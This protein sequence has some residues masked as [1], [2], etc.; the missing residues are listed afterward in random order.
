M[1]TLGS[2]IQSEVLIGRLSEEELY[3]LWGEYWNETE[4]GNFVFPMETLDFQLE[5]YTK[6]EIVRILQSP[7]SFSLTDKWGYIEFQFP[8]DR[9]SSSQYLSFCV[10]WKDVMKWVSEGH[11]D[12][13]PDMLWD[14]YQ[15]IPND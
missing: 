7:S 12:A 14:V 9:L 10:N 5:P 1:K 3:T 8:H 4:T 15:Q 6:M 13:C 2:I 11:R